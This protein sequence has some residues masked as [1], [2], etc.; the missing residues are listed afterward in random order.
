M[1]GRFTLTVSVEQLREYLPLFDLPS[2]GVARFNIAPTQPVLAVRR[3]EGQERPQGMFLRWGLIPWWAE[4][5]KIG[6]R[7]INARSDG[8]ADKP[9]FRQ[10]FQKRRCLVLADGFYEWKKGPGKKDPKQAYHIRHKD[11]SPFAFAGLWEFWRKDDERI[12]SCT[13]IT[14]DAND[15]VLPLHDRM[16]VILEPRD[17]LKWL[18]PEPGDPGR[19]LE[20][21]RPYPAEK[22]TT[23]A[24][25]QTVNN[26]NNETP[27][28]LAP[29]SQGQPNLAFGDSPA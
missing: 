18:D 9:A 4:D 27:E 15:V 21:L 19:L 26:A 29:P 8:V 5:K 12:E 24:V 6:S 14:T 13:I 23:V 2:E 1:C 3:V 17:Y 10:A 25:G 16:P 22:M 28:C 11:S 7:L 20:M